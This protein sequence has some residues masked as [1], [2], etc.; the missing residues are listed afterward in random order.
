MGRHAEEC[1]TGLQLQGERN[2]APVAHSFSE[3]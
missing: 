1:R 3:K 2:L